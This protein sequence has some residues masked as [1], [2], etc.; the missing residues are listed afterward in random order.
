MSLESFLRDYSDVYDTLYE[1][2]NYGLECDIIELLLS[3]HQ[4]RKTATILDL[5]CGTGNHVFQLMKRGYSVVGVD[6]S[7]GMIS[8]AKAKAAA[9]GISS[10]ERFLLD[11]ARS[12]ELRR[13]F[14]AVLMMFAVLGYQ[15]TNDDVVASLGTVRKH[16]RTGGLFIFDVWY[17]PA[18]LIQRPSDRIKIIQIDTGQVIRSARSRIDLANHT[19][20]VA[21][22]VWKTDSNKLVTETSEVHTM[23]YFFPL[24][25]AHYLGYCGMNLIELRAFPEIERRPD[26]TTWNVTGIA[27][28]I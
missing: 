23:R 17:G 18:V 5:G 8:V 11:D 15:T 25:L 26:E 9:S 22:T 16:L 13:E 24:E 7:E 3:R 21:Y 1:E 12:V 14:D 2:K 20:Q 19:C 4:Y 28:A 6:K 27:R 10:D